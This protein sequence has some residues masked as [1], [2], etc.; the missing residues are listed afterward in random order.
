MRRGRGAAGWILPGA[1]L[2]LL[3]KCPACLAV[4]IA[5]GTG[6]GISVSTATYLRMALVVLC[7]AALAYLTARF[8]RDRWERSRM[9]GNLSARRSARANCG[10]SK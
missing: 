5:V 10:L 1:L 4:Y 3:P 9:A 8:M 7:V 2:A 6:I